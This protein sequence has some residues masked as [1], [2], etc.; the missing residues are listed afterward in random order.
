MLTNKRGHQIHSN[1]KNFQKQAHERGKQGLGHSLLLPIS[2]NNLFLQYKIPTT[3]VPRGGCCWS[4]KA[5][6]V[7]KLHD[8]ESWG[9]GS[10]T[11]L[12]FT[13]IN[14]R[15]LTICLYFQ[16]CSDDTFIPDGSSDSSRTRRCGVVSEH[17]VPSARV[18]FALEPSSAHY[19]LAGPARPWLPMSSCH[20]ALLFTS[21]P[22]NPQEGACFLLTRPHGFLTA[23]H[24]SAPKYKGGV[25][26]SPEGG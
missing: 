14:R 2:L 26:I 5:V 24:P 23:D 11:T 7:T 19:P 1:V 6:T 18:G 20:R 15:S 8:M 12:S 9:Q 22:A 4:G 21:P 13:E 16:A 10:R 3:W 25:T 17:R